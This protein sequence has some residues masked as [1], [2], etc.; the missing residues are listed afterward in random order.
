[1]KRFLPVL[2]LIVFM[3]AFGCEK[4]D[5]AFE[6]VEKAKDLKNDIEKTADQVKKDLTSKAEEIKE[7]AQKE[8]AKVPFL[9]R[10]EKNGSG[11]DEK[12]KGRGERE[13][14]D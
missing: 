7:K 12:M 3:I 4:V 9:E 2:S 6:T 5:Q 10:K 11:E 13:A 1:M 8:V 14:E